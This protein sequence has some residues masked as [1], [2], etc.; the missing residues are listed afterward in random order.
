MPIIVLRNE[1]DRGQNL[2]SSLLAQLDD[3][4]YIESEEVVNHETILKMTDE[5][6][7]E[8]ERKDPKNE[9]LGKYRHLWDSLP[10]LRQKDR[11]GI[12]FSVLPLLEFLFE[13]EKKTDQDALL[14]PL[15]P[16]FRDTVWGQS[17]NNGGFS[18]TRVFVSWKMDMEGERRHMLTYEAEKIPKTGRATESPDPVEKVKKELEAFGFDCR[19]L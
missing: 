15:K 7:K 8:M 2:L 10:D 3:G 12:W 9:F 16:L 19:S 4:A 18:L 1:K 11:D 5:I 14:T 6:F 13:Y 17:L